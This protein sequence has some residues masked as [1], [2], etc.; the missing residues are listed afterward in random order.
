MKRIFFEMEAGRIYRYTVLDYIQDGEFYIFTD[1]VDG[2][3][4]KIH[5]SLYRGEEEMKP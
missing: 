4:R 1:T 5:K 3:E 2:K